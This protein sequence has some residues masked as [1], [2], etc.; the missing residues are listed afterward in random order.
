VG[1]SLVDQEISNDHDSTIDV[2][3]WNLAKLREISLHLDGHLDSNLS[4]FKSTL[5][6]TFSNGILPISIV[7]NEICESINALYFIRSNLKSIKHQFEFEMS[8]LTNIKLDEISS[9]L[10]EEFTEFYSFV[11]LV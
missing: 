4:L 8:N 11:V 3:G 2:S 10:I 6:D 7:A 9:L 1:E 5:D